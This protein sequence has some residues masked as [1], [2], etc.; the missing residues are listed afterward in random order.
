MGDFR[1]FNFAAT[2][3]SCL[4]LALADACLMGKTNTSRGLAHPE[5]SKL[6]IPPSGLLK[7]LAFV[8]NTD[9]LS[10]LPVIGEA[11]RACADLDEDEVMQVG[12][13]KGD[14]S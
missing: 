12:V 3:I 9:F 10:P 2:L 1:W 5:T 8:K 11:L 14:S 13:L 4:S 7:T 6:E